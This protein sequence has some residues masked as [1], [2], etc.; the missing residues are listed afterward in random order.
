MSNVLES[1]DG[2]VRSLGRLP[3]SPTNLRKMFLLLTRMHYSAPENFGE[4]ADL[5]K[6]YVWKAEE[7]RG[8]DVLLDFDFDRS[9]ARTVPAIFVG[10]TDFIY[11]RRVLDN[12][13]E[14]TDDRAGRMQVKSV[15]TTVVLRHT[16][17][18]ADEAFNLADLTA[19]FYLGAQDMMRE[20]AGFAQFEVQNLLQPKIFN[21]SPEQSYQ[22]FEA[23]VILGLQFTAT[24]WTF[25][26]SHRIKQITFKQSLAEFTSPA[27]VSQK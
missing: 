2:V 22:Q 14:F 25:T 17:A 7:P 11:S 5:L 20:Q 4:L 23:D 12:H 8:L 9:K 19:Q 26:E 13:K 27:K 15:G 6:N 3:K 10:M 21:R 18:S 24:W 16:S 1:D